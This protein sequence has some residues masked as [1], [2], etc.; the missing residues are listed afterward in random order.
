M[1]LSIGGHSG[2][3]MVVRVC[4]WL[5]PLTHPCVLGLRA[6]TVFKIGL[7]YVNNPTVKITMVQTKSVQKK[8]KENH[9]PM[10]GMSFLILKPICKKK[11]PKV[12]FAYE[13]CSWN[14]LYKL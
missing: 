10:M 8:L 2:V 9:T 4:L 13:H 3:S 1:Y 6:G 7:V 14:I 5:V 12:N 11:N